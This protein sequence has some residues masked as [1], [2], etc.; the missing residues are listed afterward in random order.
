MNL[1]SWGPLTVIKY[2]DKRRYCN[3]RIEPSHRYMTGTLWS[4]VWSR[5]LQNVLK[6]GAAEVNYVRQFF[7][8][9]DLYLLQCNLKWPLSIWITG[10]GQLELTKGEQSTLL[11]PIFP[12]SSSNAIIPHHF[13][14]SQTDCPL[15]VLLFVKWFLFSDKRWVTLNTASQ[16]GPAI[17]RLE[18]PGDFPRVLHLTS[19]LAQQQLDLLRSPS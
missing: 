18:Q 2:E 6:Q 7:Q 11:F 17:I 14:P 12:T 8:A 13:I 3:K 1:M 9:I 4:S 16:W 10:K 5:L 19:A 15:T